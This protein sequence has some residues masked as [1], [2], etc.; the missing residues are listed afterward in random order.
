MN[1]L[2]LILSFNGAISLQIRVHIWLPSRCKVFAGFLSFCWVDDRLCCH[3]VHLRIIYVYT[4]SHSI[5]ILNILVQVI[6]DFFCCIT[7]HINVYNIILLFN[8]NSMNSEF[9]HSLSQN[10]LDTLK[11]FIGELLSTSQTHRPSLPLKNYFWPEIYNFHRR[12]KPESTKTRYS[13]LSKPPAPRITNLWRRC[14]QQAASSSRTTFREK[15]AAP[16]D[17][18]SLPPRPAYMPL[19]YGIHGSPRYHRRVRPLQL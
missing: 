4:N 6:V 16:V 11:V 2:C 18:W 10:I 9:F 5:K 13:S 8:P 17:R 3:E 15:A 12:S 14:R 7:V 1:F 19:W